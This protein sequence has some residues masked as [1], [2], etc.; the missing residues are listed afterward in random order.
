MANLN[1]GIWMTTFPLLVIR[2]RGSRRVRILTLPGLPPPIDGDS[3]ASPANFQQRPSV[4]LVTVASRTSIP[5]RILNAT[6]RPHDPL[7]ERTHH[8]FAE[9]SQATLFPPTGSIPSSLCFN[10]TP[11]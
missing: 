6:E 8:A 9:A 2:R 1:I 4:R 11:L 10:C 7:E 3:H 5:G